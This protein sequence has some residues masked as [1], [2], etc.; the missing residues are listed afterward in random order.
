[1]TQ[2]IPTILYVEYKK[3]EQFLGL[4]TDNNLTFNTHQVNLIQDVT[5]EFHALRRV[6][7]YMG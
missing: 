3:K 5:Q 7:R 2:T 1:M 4:T 6:K